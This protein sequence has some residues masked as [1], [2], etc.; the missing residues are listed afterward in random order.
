MQHENYL[1]IKQLLKSQ[2]GAEG[3]LGIQEDS[4]R[5]D[6][7]KKNNVNNNARAGR[8]NISQKV[9]VEGESATY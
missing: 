1:D 8:T 7:K 9:T 2:I 6:F 4:Q 3:Q 5:N